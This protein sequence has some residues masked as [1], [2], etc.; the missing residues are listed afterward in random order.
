LPTGSHLIRMC[1]IGIRIGLCMRVID[2][3]MRVICMRVIDI[4]IGICKGIGM[5]VIGMRVIC[6]CMCVM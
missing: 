3:N 4:D 5:R 6:T 1:V 2:M